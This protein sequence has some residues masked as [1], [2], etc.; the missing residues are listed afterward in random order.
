MKNSNLIYFI[1]KLIAFVIL[2]T[3]LHNN[4][5]EPLTEILVTAELLNDNLLELPNSITVINE[6]TIQQR[7]AQHLEDLLNL[8]PNVNFASGA[9]R[10]RFIQI[11]GIG[12][13]SEFQEPIINSVGVLLDGID[14]SGIAT[15]AT[16]LDIQ[17]VEVLRGPQGTLFGA[18]ALAGMIN[19]V[20]NSPSDNFYARFTT[21]IE[22]YGGIEYSG[23]ISGPT[24]NDSA[25]RIAIK[26][27]QS[28]GFTENSFLQRDDTNNIYETSARARYLTKITIK[29]GVKPIKTK[30]TTI[31]GSVLTDSIM[32]PIFIIAVF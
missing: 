3:P 28:D 27:Y 29:R 12:E 15:A 24:T 21:A 32:P 6:K 20:S 14:I 30:Q 10:G 8:A 2:I 25:Y 13:R 9:S 5:E 7:S 1:T 19:I 26:H 18:N 23:V 17:Q 11:R 16:T 31:T 4:A 22:E